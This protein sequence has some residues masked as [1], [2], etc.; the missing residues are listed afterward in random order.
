MEKPGKS[1][2]RSSAMIDTYDASQRSNN[3]NS[4]SQ[5]SSDKFSGLKP[6]DVMQKFLEKERKMNA[7]E[8]FDFQH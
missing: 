5:K 8:L 2:Y 7:K 1:Q 4:K 6:T 3:D